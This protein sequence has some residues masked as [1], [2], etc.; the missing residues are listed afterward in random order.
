MKFAAAVGGLAGACALT[1][2]NQA[3]SKFD[4]TA[5]RLDLLGMNAVA[6]FVKGHNSAPMVIQKL[7][8]VA[9]AGDLVSNSLYY[10]LASGSTKTNTLIRGALLG[11][12][13]GLGAVA[14]PKPLGLDPLPTNLTP[15]TQ[16]LTVLYYVI[17][18]V[19]AA[20]AMNAV[21]ENDRPVLKKK[22]ALAA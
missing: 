14:L 1:L 20:A 19:I 10:A 11:L 2:I 21:T 18:G 13:A 3:I 4:K 16:G 8:P 22:S 9:I 12:G 15:K 6:K 17:G 7:F 5:P